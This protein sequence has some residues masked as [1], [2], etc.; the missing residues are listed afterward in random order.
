MWFATVGRWRLR[1]ARFP[2]PARRHW[3]ESMRCRTFRPFLLVLSG[4]YERGRPPPRQALGT[5]A[6]W[7]RTPSEIGERSGSVVRLNSGGIRF[8]IPL[9]TEE[10]C[11]VGL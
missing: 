2:V 7:V 11:G 1:N 3:P 10:E 5:C 8:R 9:E 4:K 6:K